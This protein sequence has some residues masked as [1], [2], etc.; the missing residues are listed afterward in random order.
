MSK[1]HLRARGTDRAW[2]DRFLSG[3]RH[4]AAA[5]LAG[6]IVGTARSA[7]TRATALKL[8]FIDEAYDDACQTPLQTPTSSSCAFRWVPARQT[9]QESPAAL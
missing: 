3:S 2:P 9:A 6:S 7:E 8:G 1:Q 4:E 5:G